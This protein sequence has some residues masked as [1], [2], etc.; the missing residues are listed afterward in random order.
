MR[1]F[2]QIGIILFAFALISAVAVA[3]GRP[4]SPDSWNGLMLDESTVEDAV[5]A[6]G[7]PRKDKQD[8]KLTTTILSWLD[9]NARFRKLEYK[10]VAGVDRA[11]LYFL[12]DH[13]KVIEIDLKDTF[14]AVKLPLFYDVRYFFQDDSGIL[15]PDPFDYG[16]SNYT[17]GKFPT[18]F[19][20]VGV[21][22]TS[23]LVALVAHQGASRMLYEKTGIRTEVPGSVQVIQLI[24]RLLQASDAPDRLGR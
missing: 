15:I 21:G 18:L 9:K 17:S 24:S 20:V 7:E 22:D 14:I 12:N 10:K 3:E 23:F 1:S 19:H 13:L 16:M 6:L 11:H 8:Q 4:D 5:A 2:S